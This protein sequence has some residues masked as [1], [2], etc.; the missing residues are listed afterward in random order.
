MWLQAVPERFSNS[1]GLLGGCLPLSR[2]GIE[3]L[4][5]QAPQESC[6]RDRIWLVYLLFHS[7]ASLPRVGAPLWSAGDQGAPISQPCCAPLRYLVLEEPEVDRIHLAEVVEEVVEQILYLLLF[8]AIPSPC[9]LPSW[10]W[11][12]L[13]QSSM[14]HS[15]HESVGSKGLAGP[16][17]DMGVLDREHR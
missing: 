12:R 14:F 8:S 2:G 11:H 17:T 10:L 5:R 3:L 9:L 13:G 1:L 16:W 7:R 4:R 6:R 15:S